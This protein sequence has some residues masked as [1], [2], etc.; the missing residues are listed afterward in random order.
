MKEAAEF[1]NREKHQLIELWEQRARK[2]IYAS[3]QAQSLSLR[4]HLPEMLEDILKVMEDY[5]EKQVQEEGLYE[6]LVNNSKEHG[7]HRATS[8][9]YNIEQILQEFIL[10]HQVL[11]ERMREEGV[12][13]QEAGI[14]LQFSIESSMLYSAKAYNETMLEMRQKLMGVLAHDMRNPL[15][16]TKVALD[17]M[18]LETDPAKLAKMKRMGRN[19]LNRALKLLENLLDTVSIRAGEGMV[20]NFSQTGLLEEI[21]SLHREAEEV[22]TNE[23]RLNSTG[24]SLE[25]IF[26]GTMV[27]RA[28]EN[29]LSNAVKYGAGNTPITIG[30]EDLGERVQINVHN[31]GNPIPEDKQRNI[32]DFLSTTNGSGTDDSKSWGMGLSLVVA[33]A[34]AHGG[35][36]EVSSNENDGTTFCLSLQKNYQEPG[37]K[38]VA[39]KFE[40]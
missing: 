19:G 36:L 2:R 1:L 31:E 18:E 6:E 20:L 34:Q 9:G 4:D 25:G 13:L 14:V 32:F 28:L 37:K 26:D 29:L 16:V 33:V 15:A 35:S 30:I 27:R 38:R 7:R 24:Q 3:G 23:F 22:Y 40:R 12:Y 11:I 17:V 39:L 8:P 10:F 21:Q 5:G